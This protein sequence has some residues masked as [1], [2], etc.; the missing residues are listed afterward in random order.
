MSINDRAS[1]V[2]DGVVFPHSVAFV[3]CCGKGFNGKD[4]RMILAIRNGVSR[5]SMVSQSNVTPVENILSLGT[6]NMTR[7]NIILGY[8]YPRNGR[9]ALFPDNS[10]TAP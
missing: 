9:T 6:I 2:F 10:Q 3:S 7:M 8:A 5:L 4:H 1:R